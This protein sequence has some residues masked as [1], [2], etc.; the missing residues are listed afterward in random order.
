VKVKYD[1]YLG[2]TFTP[3]SYSY[4]LPWITNSKLSQIQVTRTITAPDILFTAADMVTPGPPPN[5]PALSRSG[6]FI[7]NP[8]ASPGGGITAS[9]INPTVLVVLNNVGPMYWNMNPG[10]MD[11]QQV[12]EYP[13]WNW[14]SF[15]GTTN[16][17]IVYPMGTS[18]AELQAEALSGGASMPVNVWQPVLN[19]STNTGTGGTG[20]TGGVG[21]G[22]G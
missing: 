20:G 13:I 19:T 6:T 12:L 5:D 8:N 4:K 14:G 2:T 17:P 3:I 22:G 15:D 10:Y 18:L 21:G 9:T 1:S 7:L 16:A 11:Y